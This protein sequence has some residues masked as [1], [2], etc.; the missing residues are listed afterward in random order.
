[1]S[2]ATNP[3]VAGKPEAAVQAV[4]DHLVNQVVQQAEKERRQRIAA[5]VQRHLLFFQ[6]VAKY[7]IRSYSARWNPNAA[8]IV[9]IYMEAETGSVAVR[10]RSMLSKT[11]S[12][13]VRRL[14]HEE[15]HFLSPFTRIVEIQCLPSDSVVLRIDGFDL[16]AVHHKSKGGDWSLCH[17]RDR[18]RLKHHIGS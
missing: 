3:A 16:E 5:A 6:H 14:D 4:V 15:W 8:Y 10:V 13:E 1:M 9:R 12:L 7:P 11:T 2:I 18:F 17:H